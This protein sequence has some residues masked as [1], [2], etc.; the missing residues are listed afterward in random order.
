MQRTNPFEQFSNE[1]PPIDAYDAEMYFAEDDTQYD[2]IQDKQ[3]DVLDEQARLKLARKAERNR[4]NSE[5]KRTALLVNEKE[6]QRL[7]KKRAHVA[8][9][10][11]NYKASMQGFKRDNLLPGY[12]SPLLKMAKLL[13]YRDNFLNTHDGLCI[14]KLQ[15]RTKKMLGYMLSALVAN[16][17]VSN[18]AIVIATKDGGNNV[19]HDALRMDVALRHGVYIP[20][21]TWYF[22]FNKLVQCGYIESHPVSIYEDGHVASFYAEASHKILSKKLMAMLGA[23]CPSVKNKAAKYETDLKLKGKTFKQKPRYPSSRYKP[24]GELRENMTCVEPSQRMLDLIH[25]H[26]EREGYYSPPH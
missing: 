16:C 1:F 6:K 20:E 14:G 26:H 3:D 9:G 23:E 18:G 4:I 24:N 12:F 7:G 2:V 15:E 13:P 19:T 10:F 8:V 17:N 5:I 11:E 25:A 21:S 22:Y